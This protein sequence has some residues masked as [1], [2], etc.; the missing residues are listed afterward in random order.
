MT[1]LE[2]SKC[3]RS[4]QPLSFKII[5]VCKWSWVALISTT[6]YFSAISVGRNETAMSHGTSIDLVSGTVRH[7]PAKACQWVWP[8]CCSRDLWNLEDTRRRK[9]MQR[10][11]AALDVEF[12]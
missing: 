7:G 1:D 3:K 8:V 9:L 2:G 10:R 12:P 6:V 5:Q 11:D 4:L